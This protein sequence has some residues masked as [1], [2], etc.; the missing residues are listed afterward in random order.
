[1]R[2]IHLKIGVDPI[3]NM[4]FVL[5]KIKGRQWSV[6]LWCDESSVV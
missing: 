1:M 5:N 2:I 6:W 3:P 4:L